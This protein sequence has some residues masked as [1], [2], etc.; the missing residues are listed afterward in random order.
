[1]ALTK[2]LLTASNTVGCSDTLSTEIYVVVP[3]IDLA[4]SNFS[5]TND[6]NTNS[7]KAV[8]TILNYGNIPLIDPIVDIDLGGGALVKENVSGMIRPGQSLTQTLGLEIVPQ[9]IPYI[10]AIVEATSDVDIANNKQCVSLSSDNIVMEPYPN[11]VHDGIV[12]FDWINNNQEDVEVL[13]Y[14]SNG[15]VAF[16]QNLSQLQIGLS[17]MSINTS[18]FSN[19]LYLIQFVGGSTK[20][21]FRFIVAN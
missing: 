1:M 17:H 7:S 13:V 10:C 14:K 15:E 16:Q 21:T 5:L 4:M 12:N 11:P 6:P 18:G 9:S 20:K 3:R 19:G 8:V 2:A